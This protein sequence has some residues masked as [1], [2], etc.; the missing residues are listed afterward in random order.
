MVTITN[1]IVVVGLGYIGLPVASILADTGYK[2]LGV[3][4]NPDVVDVINRGEIHIVEPELDNITKK[5]VNSGY[6]KAS[7]TVELADI[8]IV[9]VPTPFDN[10]KKPDLSYVKSAIVAIAPLL[11]ENNLVIIESTCPVGTTD[12]MYNLIHELRPKL[13]NINFAYCPERVLPGKIIKELISNSRIV[14]GVDSASAT[15]AADFYKIFV[16]G[17]VIITDA[18]TAEMCKL[19][20]NA[21]R[22]VNIAFANE[23]SVLCDDNG[24]DVWELIKLANKH[25]R[26]D[27][28]QPGPGVGGHCI[29]VDPWFLVAD[30]AN[31]NLIKTARLINDNKP[32][33]V[34]AKIIKAAGDFV[35]P[36]IACLGA[37]FKPNIDD[38]RGSPALQIIN[39]LQQL[40]VG[41]IA[42]CDP[43]MQAT[44]NIKLV[45]LDNATEWADIIV[46]LVLHRQFIDASYLLRNK[47][48]IDIAGL[49]GRVD[50]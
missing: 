50:N 8:F 29:A 23:L 32:D 37:T 10:N 35:N 1:K 26:V 43:Y 27:I 33:I 13:Q 42:V 17:E 2:V 18:K 7:L 24:V 38:V 22:D 12:T 40:S 4:I 5:V 44:D 46:V 9:A 15:K 28:L 11:Q 25:P 3:D 34:V 20:E 41:E 39:K 16:K 30:K 47:L 31:A 19:A 14:G 6:F 21:F 36:K 48:V 45:A 49:L